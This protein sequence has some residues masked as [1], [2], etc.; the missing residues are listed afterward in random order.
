MLIGEGVKATPASGDPA[1]TA[2]GYFSNDNGSTWEN[3]Y[4]YATTS[5]RASSGGVVDSHFT[6]T[7]ML[8]SGAYV[9]SNAP[10]Y[11]EMKILTDEPSTAIYEFVGHEWSAT[12]IASMD[13]IISR[14]INTLIDGEATDIRFQMAQSGASLS[15]GTFTLY[16][17]KTS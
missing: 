6:S 3:E 8:F 1:S 10:S 16:G 2:A 15:A 7:K 14:G 17:L 12:S 11:F 4:S 5:H 9:K 13:R